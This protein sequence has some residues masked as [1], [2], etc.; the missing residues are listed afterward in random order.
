MAPKISPDSAFMAVLDAVAEGRS[1]NKITN[2]GG[3]YPC[4]ASFYRWL[5]GRCA[6][7][8]TPEILEERRAAYIRAREVQAD[9]YIDEC[10]SIA[11]EATKENVEVAKLRIHTR[12]EMAGRMRPRAYGKTI[13]HGGAEDLP[14]IKTQDMSEGEIARRIAFVLADA[15]SKG[16][17]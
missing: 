12:A 11:D 5:G 16:D 10:V 4:Y 6:Y 1:I 8:A 7:A 9:L 15:A 3:D 17:I 2:G 14:P 13:R